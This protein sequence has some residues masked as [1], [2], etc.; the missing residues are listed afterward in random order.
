MASLTNYDLKPS[1]VLSETDHKQLTVLALA[2]LN[3][4][5]DAADD[6][7]YEIERARVVPE[8]DFPAEVVCMGST[9]TYR[10]DNGTDRTVTLVYP[11]DADI[12]E[13]RISVLTPIGTALIGLA[14]GQSITW[15]ARDARKHA[16]TVL[17][18]THQS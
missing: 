9:V 16:L 18:V 1:L 10:P 6:L 5:S 4:S 17:S 15:V 13:G 3:T 12:S 11:A 7:L 14:Q 2:G 8:K